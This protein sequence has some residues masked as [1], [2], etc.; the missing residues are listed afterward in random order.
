[1][2]NG[3]SPNHSNTPKQPYV[4]KIMKFKIFRFMADLWLRNKQHFSFPSVHG[5]DTI[6]GEGVERLNKQEFGNEESRSTF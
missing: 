4:P 5:S 2:K 6:I 1:M 3:V